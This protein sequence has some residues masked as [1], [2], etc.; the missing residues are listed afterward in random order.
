[1]AYVAGNTFSWDFP[2]TTNSWR[3]GGIGGG[4][5]FLARIDT[6]RPSL[7]ALTYATYFGG[8]GY[9]VVNAIAMDPEGGLILAGYTFSND[10]PLAGAAFQTANAGD[11]D[12]FVARFDFSQPVTQSLTYSSYLGGSA[13]DVAYG[14]GLDRQGRVLLAGYTMSASFP[15]TPGASQR[16]FGGAIDAVVSVLDFEDGLTYSSFLG[17]VG[18]DVGYGVAANAQGNMIVAGTTSTRAF[19]VVGSAWKAHAE[20]L[21]EAF[22]TVFQTTPAP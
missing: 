1:M 19:P 12:M 2:T 5:V 22:F 10:L 3:A 7:D 18:M 6:S 4:D 9:D 13:T 16:G 11:T 21:S 17:G 14:L 8:T 20:G 15:V